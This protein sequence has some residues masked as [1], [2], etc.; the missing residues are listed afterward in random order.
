[1]TPSAICGRHIIPASVFSIFYGCT[2]ASQAD[3][4]I[5]S[6]EVKEKK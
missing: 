6:E 2:Q 1:M 5:S 4:A 3:G